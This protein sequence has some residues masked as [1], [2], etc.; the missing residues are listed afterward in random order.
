M[1][2]AI[3]ESI[4]KLLQIVDELHEAHP[5]KKFTLD[6]RLLGDIG[7]I[8]VEE[9][10]DIALFKGMRRHHDGMAKDG[11]LVQIKATMKDALTFPSDHRPDFYLG[12]KIKKDGSFDEVF[13]GPGRVAWEAVR[14]RKPSKTNLHSIS[15]KILAELGRRV[16]AAEK[17]PLRIRTRG[18]EL[19]RL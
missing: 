3:S 8:L 10:Y 11:R 16:S 4:K 1:S 12:I 13:N 17:I 9:N 6:G 5:A 14:N 2:K 7:E 18:T 15:I 19:E